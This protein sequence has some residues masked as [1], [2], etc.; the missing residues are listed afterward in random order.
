MLGDKPRCYIY[1]D[2]QA[3]RCMLMSVFA[4]NVM[5]KYFEIIQYLFL[6]Y[7]VIVK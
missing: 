5:T 1:L 3:F 6:S 2:V 4:V 7:I